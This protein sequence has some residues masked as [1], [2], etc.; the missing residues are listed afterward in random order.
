[1]KKLPVLLGISLAAAL[2]LGAEAARAQPTR[3][4]PVQPPKD[5]LRGTVKVDDRVG[6]GVYDRLDGDLTFTVGLGAE[7]GSGA[8]ASLLTR[9]L[10]YHTA[11]LTLG[12]TDA[13]GTS[14]PLER[15]L[16]VGAELRPLFLARWALDKEFG[17]P[18]LDLALDSLSFNC[19]MYFGTPRASS[20]GDVYGFEGGIGLG[21]PLSE[22]ARGFWLEARGTYRSGLDEG[23]LSALV[24]LSFYQ[25]WNSP[26]VR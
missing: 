24:L 6:D 7:L 20:F 1:M 10:Y 3:W 19:G 2:G 13:L 14:N 23:S 26:L 12:Y 21:V 8:R 5:G 22:S 11:G 17:V 9:A 16:S 4:E 25:P 15:A 18:V